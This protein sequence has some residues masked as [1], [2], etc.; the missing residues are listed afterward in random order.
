MAIRKSEATWKGTLR[1]GSGVMKM[2]SGSYEG[3][4]TYASRFEEGPGTNPEESIGAAHAGC[5]SMFLSALLSKAG[6]TPASIHTTATVHLGAGPTI[7]KIEL[8]CKANVPDVS[9]EQFTELAA[10]AKAGCPISKALAAVEEVTLDAQ[11]VA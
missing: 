4:F 11:L 9:A 7:T 5:Y 3:P 2:G 10:Q 8:V 1:E 6:F